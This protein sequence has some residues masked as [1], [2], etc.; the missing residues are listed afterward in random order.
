V[1]SSD[2][3]F[4]ELSSLHLESSFLCK[5]VKGHD[6]LTEVGVVNPGGALGLGVEEEHEEGEL[7]HVVERNEVENKSSKVIDDLEASEHNPVG[8]PL[9]LLLLIVLVEGQEGSE[10]GVRNS[11]QA[12]HVAGTNAEDDAGNAKGKRVAHELGLT[13]PGCFLYLLHLCRSISV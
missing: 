10:G 8:E 4:S 1:T 2:R 11:D 7:E 5:L 13:K 9:L 12:G 6:S 3:S